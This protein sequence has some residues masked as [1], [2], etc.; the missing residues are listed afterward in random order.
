MARTIIAHLAYGVA[1]V[2]EVTYSTL[3]N[4]NTVSLLRS[5]RATPNQC[6]LRAIVIV[7]I[8]ELDTFSQ[9]PNGNGRE[10]VKFSRYLCLFSLIW[11]VYFS[12][13]M[14]VTTVV[15]LYNVVPKWFSF[16]FTKRE[17]WLI[18][19]RVLV[20]WNVDDFIPPLAQF[21]QIDRLFLGFPNTSNFVKIFCCGT[22]NS[23]LCSP[24]F[25]SVWYDKYLELFLF[26]C[27]IR[28][29]QCYLSNSIWR[30]LRSARSKAL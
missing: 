26:L 28:F 30:K 27:P 22:I 11:L 19:R 17:L 6:A 21:R 23:P 5:K 16:T 10:F 1:T 14:A 8:W 3:T 20:H 4:L 12:R 15:L 9:K 7:I 24:F 29:C 25:F 13:V 2:T 18:L